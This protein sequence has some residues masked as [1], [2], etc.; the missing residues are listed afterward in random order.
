MPGGTGTTLDHK[1]KFVQHN[2]KWDRDA[3][4]DLLS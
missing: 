3:L 2:I 1:E 4:F